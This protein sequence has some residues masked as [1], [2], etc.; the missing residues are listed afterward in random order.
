MP[1]LT[2]ILCALLLA[3]PAMADWI[4]FTSPSTNFAVSYCT[5]LAAPNWTPW[6]FG[7]GEIT[8][9][10][11]TIDALNPRRVI[12]PCQSW[13][14]DVVWETA[15]NGYRFYL[16]G[17]SGV[18]TNSTNTGTNGHFVVSGLVENTTY[19]LA[20]TTY[21]ATGIGSPFSAELVLLPPSCPIYSTPV[22]FFQAGTNRLAINKVKG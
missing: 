19:Y 3:I 17:V 15:P 11:T 18:Y 12:Y 8:V 2:S 6:L 5:N 16:G 13:S 14:V 9:A 4:E 22:V 20:T 1:R 21:N 7:N 10:S